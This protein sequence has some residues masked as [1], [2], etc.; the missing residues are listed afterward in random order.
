MKP[1]RWFI[2]ALLFVASVLNYF[3]RQT[4]SILRPASKSECGLTDADS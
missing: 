1:R 2:L 4:L 3:D